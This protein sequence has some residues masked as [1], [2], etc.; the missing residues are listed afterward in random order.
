MGEGG[1]GVLVDV[2]VPVGG[3]EVT[4]VGVGVDDSSTLAAGVS[5]A[6]GDATSAEGVDVAVRG[7]VVGDAVGKAIAGTVGVSS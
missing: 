6:A 3:T 1:M 5:A 7:G 2:G 4:S